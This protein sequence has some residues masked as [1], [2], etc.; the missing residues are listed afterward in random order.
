MPVGNPI[1]VKLAKITDFYY[2]NISQMSACTEN[3][4]EFK[5]SLG[6]PEMI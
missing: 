1:F 6:F 4:W 3:R 5:K 2:R